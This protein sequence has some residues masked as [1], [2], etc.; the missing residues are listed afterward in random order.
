MPKK[1]QP[2]YFDDIKVVKRKRGFVR[3]LFSFL[4]IL[5]LAFGVVVSAD[6]IGSFIATGSFSSN[7]FAKKKE[8]ITYYLLSLG[9]FETLDEAQEMAYDSSESGSAGYVWQQEKYFVIASAYKNRKD[10]EKVLEG[11]EGY[12]PEIIEITCST[13]KYSEIVDGLNDVFADV[14]TISSRVDKSKMTA[15]VAS[16]EMNR[17][18]NDVAVMTGKCSAMQDE[19]S[20][21]ITTI[22]SSLQ[23]SMENA[24]IQLLCNTNYSYIIKNAMVKTVF[25]LYD[26]SQL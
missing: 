18:K 4:L 13:I 10:A 24:S 16:S 8:S 26:I 7:I 3:K 15:V 17:L 9:S 19:K 23:S 12:A 6:Y 21:E 22:L 2:E 5:C 11:I 1:Y 20:D 14:Y 25:A